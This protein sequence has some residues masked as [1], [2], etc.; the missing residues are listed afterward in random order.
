MHQG[1]YLVAALLGVSVVE[2]RL[3]VNT[4]NLCKNFP[5]MHLGEMVTRLNALKL[6]LVDMRM[7][8]VMVM[9]KPIAI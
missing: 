9:V 6:V 5:A 3:I 7:A 8:T 2:M 4:S 1:L